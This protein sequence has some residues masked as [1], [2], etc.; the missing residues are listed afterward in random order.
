MKSMPQVGASVFSHPS[1]P[2]SSLPL[3]L[4][5]LLPSFLSDC[6]HFHRFKISLYFEFR[7]Y[8]TLRLL[9]QYLVHLLSTTMYL[10]MFIFIYLRERDGENMDEYLLPLVHYPCACI[11][12]GCPWWSQ[13][14]RTQNSTC[15]L[16]ISSRNQ[17]SYTST[18][19]LPVRSI[20]IK[21]YCK[22]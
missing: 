12:Q 19:Y 5:F 13:E 18:C 17:R 10:K 4:S 3:F 14:L 16:L 1:S 8:F 22:N 9:S 11:I 6:F 21:L 15:I 20:S 2:L 7:D